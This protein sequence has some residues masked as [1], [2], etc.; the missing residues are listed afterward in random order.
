MPFAFLD[1]KEEV[2]RLRRLVARREGALGVLYGRRRCGK[3]RLLHE[4]LRPARSVYYVADDRESALQRASL[5]TEVA[6]LIPG[7]DRV[8][9][10]EWSALFARLWTEAR[11]GTVLALDEFPAL[12]AV[13][14]EAPS[15]LQKHLDRDARGGVHLLLAGSSQRMMQGL[16]LERAAPLYGRA[17]EI[18]K[19]GPLAPGWI[20]KALRLADPAR[21]V[22]AYAVWGGVPRYWELAA[23]HPSLEAA[24]RALVLSS[25]GVLYD[26]PTG[27]LLDDLRDTTQASSILSLIGQ[28]CHRL[29]EIAGR[30][31]KPATSLSR[32]MQRL[33]ELG[34]VRREVPFGAST[35][36][37]KRT[38][39]DVVDPFMRFWYRFVEPNRSRLEAGRLE[40]VVGEVRG[41]LA[42]HV[43]GVWEELA[44]ASVPRLRVR[45][46]TWG[47]AGRWWGPGE[48]R[49][50]L[51]VDVVAESEDGAALLIGEAE[52][53]DAADASRLAAELQRKTK[54]F[55]GR[56]KRDVVIALWLRRRPRAR[57][58]AVVFTPADVLRVLR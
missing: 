20:A 24:V 28:G 39:Y 5:A 4:V 8:G 9:Y 38:T 2:S 15:L 13:A 16:V 1:R 26:E 35:R 3:S 57:L 33:V 48:D 34:L 32:P 52:W 10:P 43:A 18:M 51:E 12:V 47:P 46:H 22:E 23:E 14:P 25:L 41:R 29:S 17:V 56:G 42:A 36:D 44:R 7:F 37:T 53:G 50:P 55:P 58:P 31:A 19:V 54:R 27:L 40:A 6:R 49:R 11:R 21:A 30:L 45:G